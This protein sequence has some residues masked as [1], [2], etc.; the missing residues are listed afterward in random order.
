MA[1][2]LLQPLEGNVPKTSF[3]ASTASPPL[4]IR[5][6][7]GLPH[8]QP[9]PTTRPVGPTA[10]RI[11]SEGRTRDTTRLRR[12]A[13]SVGVRRI[14]QHGLWTSD[15]RFTGLTNIPSKPPRE[16]GRS[17]AQQVF[18]QP[19]GRS[20]IG[21]K[22]GDQRADGSGSLQLS[23]FRQQTPAKSRERHRKLRRKRRYSAHCYSRRSKRPQ[24]S[25]K[26][27]SPR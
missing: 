14:F 17:S 23:L 18:R 8:Q 13:S 1:K 24:H 26:Q 15:D 5:A 2:H 19:G 27:P 22:L 21:E 7:E 11:Q 6:G 9:R 25:S 12:G 16:A 3:H 20:W 4:L 10:F